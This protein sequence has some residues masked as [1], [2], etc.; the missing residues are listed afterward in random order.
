MKPLLSGGVTHGFSR[1]L[2]VRSLDKA[3]GLSVMLADAAFI[4]SRS[5]FEVGGAGRGASGLE[6]GD[7]A[8]AGEAVAVGVDGARH[9]LVGL[10]VVDER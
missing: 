1:G 10:W 8:G 9:A 3:V 7:D 6:G 2:T 5:V 4:V